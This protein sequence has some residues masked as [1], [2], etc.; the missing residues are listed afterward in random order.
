VLRKNGVTGAY[1]KLKAL[2]RGERVTA[3]KLHEFVLGLEISKA[4]KEKLLNI[5]LE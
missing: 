1:E 4:E 3:E 2:T 5:V